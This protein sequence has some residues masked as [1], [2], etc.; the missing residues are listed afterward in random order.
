MATI[1]AKKEV[2]IKSKLTDIL[3]DV[4]WAKIAM[5]YFGKSSSWIYHKIDGIDGNGKEKGFS[6]EE[7]EQFKNALFDL[8]ERIRKTAENL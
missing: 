6:K 4:S 5:R 8:S 7:K 2:G 1:T 3:V